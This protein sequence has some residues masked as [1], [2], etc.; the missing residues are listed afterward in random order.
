MERKTED[1]EKIVFGNKLKKIRET[2][3]QQQESTT[4]LQKSLE[5]IQKIIKPIKIPKGVRIKKKK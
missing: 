5:D 1:K 4:I 2:L 3:R